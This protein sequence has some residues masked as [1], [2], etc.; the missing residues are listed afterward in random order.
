MDAYGRIWPQRRKVS[1]RT[2]PAAGRTY[3]FIWPLNI[4][5]RCIWLHMATYGR[6]GGRSV[7]ALCLQRGAHIGPSGRITLHR[8]AHGIWPHVAAYGLRG[9]KSVHALRPQRGAHIGLSGSIT[10]HPVA[11]G[12][13][14]PHMAAEAESQCTHCARNRAH[15]LA[16]LAI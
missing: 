2:L 16:Y 11:C 1:A 7:H 8:G 6:R 3:W 15:I 5:S 4:A 13:I 12:Y 14:W 9:G 10:L